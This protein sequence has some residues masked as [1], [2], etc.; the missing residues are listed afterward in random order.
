MVLSAGS[1]LEQ[2]Q[3]HIGLFLLCLAAYRSRAADFS[4]RLTSAWSKAQRKLPGHSDCPNHARRAR[5]FVNDGRRRRAQCANQISRRHVH[6]I[7]A[8]RRLRASIVAANAELHR[9]RPPSRPRRRRPRRSG[10]ISTASATAK[11]ASGRAW[12]AST[13]RFSCA[14]RAAAGRGSQRSV[15][16]KS[17]P[18]PRNTASAEPRPRPRPR[19]RGR[20]RRPAEP[21]GAPSQQ[22]DDVAVPT[23]RLIHT[24]TFTSPSST[25]SKAPR[26]GFLLQARRR[27]LPRLVWSASRLYETRGVGAGL[28]P[29][30]IGRSRGGGRLVLGRHRQI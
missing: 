15:R 3:G 23:T 7:D 20:P 8:T 26:L 12:T 11:N 5:K 22:R 1:A 14:R 30:R 21:R 19:R 18:R 9:S 27:L 16:K 6:A 29:R 4:S 28:E 13:C 17:T 25:P 24:T 10:E 2:S